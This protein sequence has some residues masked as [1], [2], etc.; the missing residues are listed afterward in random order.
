MCLRIL[1][2]SAHHTGCQC[3]RPKINS[4]CRS[5]SEWREE[6]HEAY[7]GEKATLVV[8]FSGHVIYLATV[9]HN[10]KDWALYKKYSSSGFQLVFFPTEQFRDQSMMGEREPEEDI[11]RISE[12][13]GIIS[14]VMDYVDV[15][16]VRY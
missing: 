2:G 3:W 5:N 10:A 1:W 7:L 9:I 6:A 13:Y 4:K 11:R 15:N 16:G 14:P 8:N 12:E